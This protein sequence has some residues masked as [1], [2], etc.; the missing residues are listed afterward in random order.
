MSIDAPSATT[1]DPDRTAPAAPETLRDAI[2]GVRQALLGIELTLVAG[3]I[4]LLGGSSGLTGLGAAV[5]GGLGLI[6][7]LTG[8]VAPS[9]KRLVV[10]SRPATAREVGPRSS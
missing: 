8:A 6:L 1:S 2:G 3:L 7:V 10:R 4:I 9:G 5:V